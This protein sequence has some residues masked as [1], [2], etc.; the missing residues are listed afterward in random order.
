MPT[1]PAPAAPADARSPRVEDEIERRLTDGGRDGWL[2]WERHVAPAAG[3]AHPVRLRGQAVT[4]NTRTGE[5]LDTYRSADAPDGLVYK[6]CGTRRA[7][8]CPS[9][10]RTYQ[11]DAYH[12]L[13]AGLAGSHSAGVP[14][15]VALRPV[16]LLT[17]TAP[18]F[19]LVHGLRVR[20]GKPMPCRA[21]RNK[22]LC[23]HGRPTWCSTRHRPGDPLIGKPL[24]LD[25]YDHDAHVVWNHHASELWRRTS[26]ALRRA[27]TRL[28]RAHGVTLRIAFGKVAEYQA[29]GVVHFHALIRLD[30]VLAT[31]DGPE[32][33]APPDCIHADD[34]ADVLRHA[35][36]STSFG[37]GPH[38]D[39][40]RGVGWWMSWGAQVDVR[41]V[42]DTLTAAQ[43]ADGQDVDDLDV[44]AYLAKYATKATEAVGLLAHRLTAATIGAYA[45]QTTHAGRLIAA[46]WR[47][48]R[49]SAL[50]PPA[51][52]GEV[53]PYG[54]LRKWAHMLGFGG[55]F[56]T[57]SRAYSTTFTERRGKRAKWRRRSHRQRLR[58]QRPDLADVLDDLAEDQED[59]TVLV[60]GEWAY[61]GNGWLSEGD[62]VLANASAARARE[63][64]DLIREEIRCA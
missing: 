37:T 18:S 17:L 5:V 58:E 15:D 39:S 41:P 2:T 36:A 12:L 49:P 64:S 14:E 63:Y 9:C 27:V 52:P 16:V 31:D 3:C 23:P 26:I 21:R 20:Q 19:G 61:A 54:R 28:G 34:L 11:Y 1:R 25:C 38:P 33:V 22:P 6:P 56:L 24:C 51:E 46:A 8:V 4:V 47:L 55:H 30:A 59:E 35:C 32:L 42:R 48:G 43:L 50:E 60:I 57:K 13:K 53:P 45:D 29:R 62:R 10:A 7:S 44:A 40:P